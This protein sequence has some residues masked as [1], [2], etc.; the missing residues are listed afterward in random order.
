MRGAEGAPAATCTWKPGKLPTTSD[1][2]KLWT[3]TLLIDQWTE[4]YPRQPAAGS[5]GR[6]HLVEE[7]SNSSARLP[8]GASIGMKIITP[9]TPGP[10][11][12]LACSPGRRVVEQFRKVATGGKHRDENHHTTNTGPSPAVRL[13][14]G[15]RL[16]DNTTNEGPTP[17][18]SSCFASGWSLAKP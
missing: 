2:A 1:L 5:Y 17:V 12:Q 4:E 7:R 15:G 11:Q 6:L 14:R 8:M 10:H 9:P 18:S 3:D 13:L 16:Q